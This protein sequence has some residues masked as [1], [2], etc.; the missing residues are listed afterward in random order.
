MTY[1]SFD[2]GNVAAD[3]AAAVG[4]FA[5]GMHCASFAVAVARFHENWVAI[6][7]AGGGLDVAYAFDAPAK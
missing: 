4:T 6:G 7:T 2:D 5:P 3:A 1:L